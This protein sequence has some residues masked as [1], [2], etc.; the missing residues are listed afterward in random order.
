VLGREHANLRAAL[1]WSRHNPREVDRCLRLTCGMLWLW[2]LHN[3]LQ[4]GFAAAEESLHFAGT[5]GSVT[6]RGRAFYCAGSLAWLTGAAPQAMQYLETAISLL[7]QTSE[8]K[9]L[10]YAIV[11]SALMYA[12]YGEAAEAYRRLDESIE[13]FQER[14]YL[15]GLFFAQISLGEITLREGRLSDARRIFEAVTTQIGYH[16]DPI[17]IAYVLIHI[18]MIATEEGDCTTA[19]EYCRRGLALAQHHGAARFEALAH[20]G[21]GRIAG[22]QQSWMDSIAAY[23]QAFQRY[24]RL[25]DR[26]G[27]A[28]CIDGLVRACSALELH[29]CVMQLRGRVDG[30]RTE[31]GVQRSPVEERWVATARE[32][33]RVR[34]SPAERRRLYDAGTAL[35]LP[36]LAS[37]V[38]NAIAEQRPPH[39]LASACP[40]YVAERY[41][42]VVD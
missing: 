9:I 35:P 26:M 21:L 27:S 38:T 12:S 16:N 32:R 2:Y 42:A 1:T 30:L 29:G 17:N 24:T 7:R 40:L 15:E 14:G 28:T 13:L 31:I 39:H 37:V 4:E 18:G 3:H 36:E 34:L 8:Q 5:A 23:I 11:A 6:A 20:Q 41:A 22:E 33:A 25:G 10:G 19:A